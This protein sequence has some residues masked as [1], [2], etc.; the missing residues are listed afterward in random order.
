MSAPTSRLATYMRPRLG[1]C[2]WN[3]FVKHANACYKD[4]YVSAFVEQPLECVGPLDGTGCPHAFCVDLGSLKAPSMLDLEMIMVS[5]TMASTVA[6]CH[7]LFGVSHDPANPPCLHLR[8]GPRLTSSKTVS[9]AQ[10]T[11]CHTS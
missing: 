3:A 5:R 6:L 8:C 1:H 10:H 2:N 7:S 11:Y 4:R 9:Y